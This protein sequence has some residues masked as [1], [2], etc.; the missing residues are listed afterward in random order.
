MLLTHPT[1]PAALLTR[2]LDIIL[3][4]GRRAQEIFDQDTVV[5]GI[6]ED[7]HAA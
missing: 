2:V 7:H 5:V 1:V 3:S 4:A 6:S